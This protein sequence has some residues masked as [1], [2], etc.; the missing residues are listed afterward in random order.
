MQLQR[1]VEGQIWMNGKYLLDSNIIIALFSGDKDVLKSIANAK[2]VFISSTVLGELYFGVYKSEH[3]ANNMERIEN[4]ISLISIF[5][6]DIHTAKYYGSI[7]NSL[8][9]IGK[10]IPE[11]DIWIAATAKQYN[12]TLIS[13]DEHFKSIENLKLEKW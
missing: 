13:R 8:K 4:F 6:L 5:S 11:N 3:I 2:E 10:P 12:L 7:K 1:N 9:K